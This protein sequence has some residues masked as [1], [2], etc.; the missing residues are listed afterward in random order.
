[1]TETFSNLKATDSEGAEGEDSPTILSAT[2]RILEATLH[3]MEATQASKNIR[4]LII[5][6]KIRREN[7]PK[8]KDKTRVHT[9]PYFLAFSFLILKKLVE[10][11]LKT[12]LFLMLFEG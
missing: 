1:M 6:P 8:Q 11:W 10:R 9:C 3:I 2:S 5:S 7:C 4:G 12:K